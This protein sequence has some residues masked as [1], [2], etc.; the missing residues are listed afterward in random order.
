M[1]C[2]DSCK[3]LIER[4]WFTIPPKGEIPAIPVRQGRCRALPP[5]AES[6]TYS[7]FPPIRLSQSCGMHA[8]AWRGF[9]RAVGRI[10]GKGK[11]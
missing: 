11:F 2:C 8:F 6:Y 7:Y 9:W 4:E 3:H 10:F 1:R 5:K